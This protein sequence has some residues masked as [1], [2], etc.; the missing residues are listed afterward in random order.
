MTSAWTYYSPVFDHQA[1][2]GAAWAGHRRFAYDLARN[3][4]PRRIVELG[5]CYGTSFFA[6]CQGVKDERLDTELWAIDTWRGDENTSAYGPEVWTSF[7]QA[8]GLFPEQRITTV[9]A[10]FDEARPRVADGSVDVLHIDGAHTYDAVR[11]DYDTWKAVMSD[12]GVI[13]FHD[14][15]V[16]SEGFGVYRLWEEL[17]AAWPT[18]TFSHSYGLGVLFM[19]A[20]Y[21]RCQPVVA[22][23]QRHYAS[24]AGHPA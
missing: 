10:S 2:T 7:E 15:A 21:A 14:V 4:Q 17:Q 5:V 1:P 6:F 19:P 18:A 3:L 20:A 11:H 22:D 12:R 13:L 9:H 16:R 8:L 23:W 24:D